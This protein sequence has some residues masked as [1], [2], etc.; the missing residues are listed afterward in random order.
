MVVEKMILDTYEKEFW[1][2][3]ALLTNLKRCEFYR[4]YQLM[5]AQ[6]QE[7]MKQYVPHK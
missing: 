4:I 3:Q 5:E 2:A 7:D 6:K 1:S